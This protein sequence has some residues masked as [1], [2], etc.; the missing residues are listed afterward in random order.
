MTRLLVHILVYK[1]EK[2]YYFLNLAV[3]AFPLLLTVT[4]TYRPSI[5]ANLY[6]LPVVEM[7]DLSC[8]IT[9]QPVC[10]PGYSTV[11]V[12]WVTPASYAT[13]ETIS[14]LLIKA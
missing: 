5:H 10:K 3:P 9:Q 7:L 6:R 14:G 8:L 11:T 2:V 12:N 4:T 13:V 1:K